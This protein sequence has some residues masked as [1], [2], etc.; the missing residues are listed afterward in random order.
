MGQLIGLV[1][2]LGLIGLAIGVILLAAVYI[3]P[4]VA[5][6]AI[7]Y[8]LVRHPYLRVRQQYGA[9]A[10]RLQGNTVP[11]DP[12]IAEAILVRYV[13]TIF[14]RGLMGRLRSMRQPQIRDAMP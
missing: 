4:A 1:V 14:E 10:A 8:W 9:A 12:A 13:P 2:I 5:V 7:V 3:L 6:G 11:A